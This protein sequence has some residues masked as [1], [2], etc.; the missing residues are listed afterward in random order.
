MERFN[1]TNKYSHIALNDILVV[2][3]SY[4]LIEKY[5]SIGLVIDLINNGV[6]CEEDGMYA[7]NDE[8]ESTQFEKNIINE[9]H[10]ENKKIAYEELIESSKNIKPSVR[11]KLVSEFINYNMNKGDLDIVKA[12]TNLDLNYEMTGIEIKKYRTSYEVYKATVDSIKNSEESNEYYCLL[13]LLLQS[14]DIIKIFN[15]DEILNT[16]NKLKE[17]TGKSHFLCK[18]EQEA[19]IQ[20]LLLEWKKF[21]E[22]KNSMFKK[23][24]GLGV[25]SRFPALERKE[26]IFISTEKMFSNPQERLKSVVGKLVDNGH[27][28]TVI[29]EG[30]TPLV[31]VDNVLYEL[32]PDAVKVRFMNVHG[33]RLRRYVVE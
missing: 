1:I 8:I 2:S 32:V 25:V 4:K 29:R 7:L 19:D 6:I 13:W 24:F 16:D 23:G 30:E 33:V 10:I 18:L 5:I 17:F 28:V 11:E 14:G 26:S 22:A 12:L 20:P 31:D 3:K 21:V 9:L 15:H 27:M